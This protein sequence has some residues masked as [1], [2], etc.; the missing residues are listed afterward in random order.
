VPSLRAL[1]LGRLRGCPSSVDPGGENVP[2]PI[3]FRGA[4]GTAGALLNEFGGS[5][6]SRRFRNV[7]VGPRPL[8]GSCSEL[9][10]LGEV[11]L[12]LCRRFR[13][14]ARPTGP[15]IEVLCVT[16]ELLTGFR[17]TAVLSAPGSERPE[18]MLGIMSSEAGSVEVMLL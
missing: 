17:V 18:A 4:L 2:G 5:W 8:V 16:L 13:D 3:D 10:R 6:P 14:P 1:R 11:G 12:P 9:W 7:A 15:V